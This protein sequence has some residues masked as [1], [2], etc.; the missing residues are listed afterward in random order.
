[1]TY[2]TST[3][4]S[5]CWTMGE[6][7]YINTFVMVGETRPKSFALLTPIKRR[8][9]R[10]GAILEMHYT[11]SDDMSRHPSKC[12]NRREVNDTMGRSAAGDEHDQRMVN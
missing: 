7:G 3:G 6:K 12:R 9:V 10:D 4:L 11:Y 1:M 8:C 5:E 2:T